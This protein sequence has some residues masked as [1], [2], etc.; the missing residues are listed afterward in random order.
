MNTLKI[1]LNSR[2]DVAELASVMLADHGPKAAE[3]VNGGLPKRFLLKQSNNGEWVTDREVSAAEMQAMINAWRL[4]AGLKT[5][6]TVDDP[7]LKF[8]EEEE[9]APDEE[10]DNEKPPPRLLKNPNAACPNAR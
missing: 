3:C 7:I 2:K 6:T 8:T 1:C 5:N 4:E 9:E 10:E